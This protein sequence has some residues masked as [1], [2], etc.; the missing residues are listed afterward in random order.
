[1]NVHISQYLSK[2]KQQLVCLQ[3]N[4]VFG[5]E[6]SS[7]CVTVVAKLVATLHNESHGIVMTGR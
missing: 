1:M 3:K 7:E 5:L 4:R 6:S 2:T